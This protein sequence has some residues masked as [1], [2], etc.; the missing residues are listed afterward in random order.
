[1]DTPTLGQMIRSCRDTARLTQPQAA[2][3]AGV[4]VGTWSRVERD[5]LTPEP[6]YLAA[7]AAAVN[8]LPEQL[9]A[10]GLT[11]AAALLHARLGR[12]DGNQPH[13][14]P[15]SIVTAITAFQL[16][17][18]DIGWSVSLRHPDADT[19]LIELKRDK[20]STVVSPADS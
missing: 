8:C 15:N 12:L 1:M 7:M 17:A 14:S 3:L 2:A 9:E 6:R 4:S 16:E 19:Y 18:L 20:T 5:R 11:D 10:R 13:L